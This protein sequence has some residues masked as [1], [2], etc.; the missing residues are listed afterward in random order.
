MIAVMSETVAE[1]ETINQI[2]D[3]VGPTAI[4]ETACKQYSFGPKCCSSNLYALS[5]WEVPREQLPTSENAYGKM[6]LEVYE[7]EMK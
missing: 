1:C 3:F 4:H 7:T 5:R 2:R 6:I